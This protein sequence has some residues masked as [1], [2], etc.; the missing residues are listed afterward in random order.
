MKVS[1][2]EFV[3]SSMQ[4][5]YNHQSYP[6]SPTRTGRIDNLDLTRDTG[7]NYVARLQTYFIAP[8]TGKGENFKCRLLYVF[9]FSFKTKTKFGCQQVLV[10]V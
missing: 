10:S 1:K 4:D 9:C 2:Y 6:D 3:T 8:Q 7:S 5:V